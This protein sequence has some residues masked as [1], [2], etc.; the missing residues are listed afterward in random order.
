MEFQLTAVIQ[1]PLDEVFGFFRDVD[2]H[3]GRKGTLVPVLDQVTPGPVG[4]GTRYHEVVQVLPFMTGEIWTEVVGYEPGRLLAYR[5]VA[6]GMDGELT[7]QFEAV[8]EGTRLVQRQSL[9][10]KGLLKVFS[11][12]IGAVFSRMIAR[13]L[14]GI[15]ALLE[16]GA[17]ASGAG[18]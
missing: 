11:P 6:L 1:R 13:R 2:Q 14:A 9:Q 16:S 18:A 3:A 12:M 5:F 7:Y 8:A 17:L 10:P 4:V 15:K